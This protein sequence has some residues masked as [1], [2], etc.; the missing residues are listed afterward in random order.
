[1]YRAENE[2][3]GGQGCP[4]CNRERLMP[5]AGVC[6]TCGRDLTEIIPF[7]TVCPACQ[8]RWFEQISEIQF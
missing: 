7:D 8:E 5:P 4:L 1:M 6:P 2:A 3:Q